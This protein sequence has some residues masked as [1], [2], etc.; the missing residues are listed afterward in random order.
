MT[1]RFVYELRCRSASSMTVD[2]YR[3]DWR[4]TDAYLC[5]MTTDHLIAFLF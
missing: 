5:Y 2:S 1:E 3:S 4:S